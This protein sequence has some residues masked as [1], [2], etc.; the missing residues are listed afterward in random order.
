VHE[1]VEFFF[2]PGSRYCYLA[3]SQIPALEAETGCQVDWRPVDGRVLRALRGRDPFLGEPASGQYDWN[4]R[5][6]DAE[7]WAEYYEIP[8]REPP[9]HDLDFQL[10]VRAAVA[11]KRLGGVAPY[12]WRLCATVYASEAWP[13]DEALCI[14]LADEI[15]LPKTEFSAMLPDAETKRQM[16]E[17]AREA[18]ARGA[19]GVPTFF[20]RG[21]M[22]WCNDRLLLVCHC[23]RKLA[24]RS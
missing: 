16:D 12:G 7:A 15:R 2:S 9:D 14:R 20:V 17:A 22:F 6:T 3:A 13:L 23:L 19:F 21:R 1:R 4:Y 11:A 18:H 10:L 24:G 5:R 8:F